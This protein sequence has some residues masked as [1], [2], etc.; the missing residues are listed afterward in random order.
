[1]EQR[2]GG[3]RATDSPT[4]GSASCEESDPPVPSGDPRSGRLPVDA[5]APAEVPCSA[6][7][8]PAGPAARG[9][10]TGRQSPARDQGHR[11]RRRHR[12]VT[13]LCLQRA[14][15]AASQSRPPAPWRTSR[16]SRLARS[17]DPVCAR[18]SSTAA[19]GG[20]ECLG[21]PGAP[22]ARAAPWS[23]LVS[24][25]R[26]AG[27]AHIAAALALGVGATSTIQSGPITPSGHETN[28]R[29]RGCPTVLLVRASRRGRC[30][31]ARGRRDLPGW[32]FRGSSTWPKL[33]TCSRTAQ[34]TAPARGGGARA[35]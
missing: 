21:S 6:R 22:G 27:M 23:H 31:H 33:R 18:Y 1:M 15:P 3:T 2:V 10:R 25:R 8:E 35:V 7:R 13:G 26:A 11:W 14:P 16:P 19:P 4:P 34:D 30:A 20:A 32:R 9:I 17:P 29:R 28:D 24:R 5:A 12:A